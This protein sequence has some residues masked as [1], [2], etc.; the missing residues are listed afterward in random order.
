MDQNDR[1]P[2]A[3][4]L[5]VDLDVVVVFC[6]NLDVRHLGSFPLQLVRSTE[7]SRWAAFDASVRAPTDCEIP[8]AAER[9][10]AP[11]ALITTLSLEVERREVQLAGALYRRKRDREVLDREAR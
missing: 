7:S 4:V 5:V 3:V 9:A 8:Q 2:A 11:V 1:L 6:A 10:Y